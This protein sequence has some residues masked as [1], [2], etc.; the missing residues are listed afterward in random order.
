MPGIYKKEIYLL[1][2]EH[3]LED[4]DIWETSPRARELVG[5]V[6]FPDPQPKYMNTVEISALQTFSI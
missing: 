4:R 6:L 3:M 2:S 1:T 5:P